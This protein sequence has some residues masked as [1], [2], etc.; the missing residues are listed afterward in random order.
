[1]EQYCTSCINHGLIGK[2]INRLK[3]IPM[4]EIIDAACEFL[5]V[6]KRL[7]MGKE[8]YRDRVEKR[9]M[10]MCY[11]SRERGFLLTHIGK[12]LNRDHTTVIHAISHVDDLCYSDIDFQFQYNQLVQ[13]LNNL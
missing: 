11:L 6:E 3:N 7:I 12:E 8:R 1:M 4:S 2:S 9:H 10:I 5:R 13:H